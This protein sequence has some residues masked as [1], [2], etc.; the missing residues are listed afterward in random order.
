MVHREINLLQYDGN[1]QMVS[2]IERFKTMYQEVQG[3]YHWI[4]WN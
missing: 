1:G 3:L 2:A 4:H